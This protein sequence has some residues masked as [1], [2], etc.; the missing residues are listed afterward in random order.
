MNKIKKFKISPSNTYK[1]MSGSVGL[2]EV[3]SAKHNELFTRK[4]EHI[5]GK[6]G[7]KP[8][9]EIMEKEL[10]GLIWKKEN[11]QLPSGAI[12]YLKEWYT[13]KK[14]NR[15]KEWFNKFVDKGLAVEDDGIEMLSIHLN[16]GV[17]LEKNQKFFQNEY[18]H[19]FPDVFHEDTVYDIKCAWDVF[20]FP[21]WEKEI[22]DDKYF[23]QMQ[24][25]MDLL[26]KPKAQVVYC[27]ID[28]P[29]PLVD[30]ELKKLYYQSGGRAED[31]T[32]ETHDELRVNYTF[33]DIPANEKIKIYSIEIDEAKIKEI[34]YRVKLCREY[35]AKN[36]D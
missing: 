27:L 12:T 22:P 4:H 16:E 26:G 34:Y 33:N 21:F 17:Q 20:S 28:T 3:Q 14:Y 29:K 6:P 2:T 15:K 25:Y 1:I 23:W 11:P 10:E 5:S 8:L 30:L 35:I 7:I 9:T 18:I 36:F 13:S 31:W 24:S 32:P 19:G